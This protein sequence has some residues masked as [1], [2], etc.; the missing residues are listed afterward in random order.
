MAFNRVERIREEI[1]REL[2]SV[3]RTIKDPRMSAMTSIVEADVTKD[4]KYAKVYV[5]VLGTDEDKKNTMEALKSATGY[6]KREIGSRL[7]LRCVPHPTFVLDTSIDYG[8]HINDLLH[9]IKSEDE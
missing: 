9:K 8:M 3:I 6:I 7:D 5:S 4:L 2:S 1:K